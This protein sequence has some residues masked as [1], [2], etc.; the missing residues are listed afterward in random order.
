MQQFDPNIPGLIEGNVNS[1]V[2]IDPALTFPPF[3]L[4]NSVLDPSKD[5]QIAVNW[6]ITGLLRPLWLTA[7]GGNW[8]VQVFAESLGGGP[9]ILL[10]RDDSVAADPNVFDYAVTLTVPAGTLPEGNPGSEVSGIYKLVASVFLDS[11]L[12]SPGFDMVGFNEGP[13]IQ[14]ENP[15]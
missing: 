6:S 7:L 3:E 1:V 15:N 11:T 4:G 10:A 9:E 8:N 13:I 5:F 2:A 12:P 14:I